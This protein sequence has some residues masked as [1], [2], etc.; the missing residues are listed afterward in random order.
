MKTVVVIYAENRSFNNLFGDF[1][2][3]EKPLSALEPADY[4]QR[5]RDGSLLQ[6]LPPTDEMIARGQEPM[7]DLSNALVFS[8]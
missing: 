2:G 8:A 1:P 3:V 5:N 4:Q 6:T 7:G